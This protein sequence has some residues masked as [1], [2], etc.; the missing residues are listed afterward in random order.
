MAG[1]HDIADVSMGRKNGS[2]SI[3]SL[4]MRRS[5]PLN[6]DGPASTGARFV[7]ETIV[8]SRATVHER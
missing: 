3:G 4:N 8:L 1:A 5:K 2:S 6:C 7:N